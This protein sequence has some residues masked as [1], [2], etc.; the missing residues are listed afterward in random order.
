MRQAGYLERLEKRIAG[1]VMHRWRALIN[2]IKGSWKF[3][4]REDQRPVVK[5]AWRA[6]SKRY[7][8]KIS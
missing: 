4:I 7:F 6:E 1:S 3:S 2:A 5:D 8:M